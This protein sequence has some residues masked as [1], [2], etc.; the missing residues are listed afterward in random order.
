M[1]RVNIPVPPIQTHEGGTAKR[2][3]PELQLRRSVM[4]CLLWEKTFYEDG[5]DIA[6]RIAETIPKVAPAL[7]A[8]I[9]I[10]ARE[11]MKLRHVPLLIVREM[12]RYKD[13]RGLVADTLSRVIQRAD[14]LAEFLAIYW[15]EKKQPLS[16]QV[17]KGLASAFTKFSAYD[18]AKYNRDGA[19]KLRDVLFL[20]HAKP[21]D[22]E[23]AA[24]WKK[25]VD[26]TLEPP[27]TWEVEL[28][29]GKDKKATWERLMSEKKL[30]AL[31]FLRNLRNMSGVSVDRKAI[32]EYFVHM[33]VDRVLPYR[34]IAAARY[35]PDLEPEL[36]SAMLK[37]TEGAEKIKGLTVLLVD[38]SG[39]MNTP[40]SDKSDLKRF[41]A[42]CGLAIL[43]RELCE[44]VR[45][46][47][48]SEWLC[49]V[50]PR[51][52]FALRDAIVQSQPHGGTW[53]GAAVNIL[54]KGNA[55]GITGN[56]QNQMGCHRDHYSFR[57][58]SK[59]KADY[60]GRPAE[61]DRLI[62]ITDEQSHDSIPDPK[63]KGYVINVAAYKNGVGYGAWNHIDGW[64]EAVLTYIQRSE[65]G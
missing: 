31:A 29:A 48:F 53:L 56:G 35:A 65:E 33:K 7:V 21:K 57:G 55:E 14:E 27:D 28:S 42:A 13:C 24:T 39:S 34:F 25:L 30:G 58:M 46:F 3:G 60:C 15:K 59:P 43:A 23:Q 10:E 36:E 22:D 64:S 12:A 61:Y 17:K 5:E 19:V 40:I 11:K 51:R 16:A 26:G 4:A 41:D 49:E 9:A 63:G 62:V 6:S 20:C 44:D 37:A 8:A 2:I 18:L 45:V 32:K 52:G 47:T 50:P 54:H 1:A 38:V